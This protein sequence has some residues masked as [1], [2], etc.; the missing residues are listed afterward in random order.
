MTNLS[1]AHSSCALSIIILAKANTSYTFRQMLDSLR[2]Q[3]IGA[4]EILVIDCNSAGDPYSLSL[5]EDISRLDDVRLL[6]PQG[7]RTIGE[8]CNTALEQCCGDYVCFINSSDEWYASKAERQI[9]LLEQAPDSPACCC[10]GYLHASTS[11][12]LD[13]LLIFDQEDV[14]ITRW[15]TTDQF[16][17]SS[18][19]LYRRSALRDAGGFDG[20]LNVCLHQ[21]ALIRLSEHAPVIFCRE[22]LF[23]CSGASALSSP[24]QEYAAAKHLFYKHYDM[25][26]KNRREYQRCS[27]HLGKLAGNC[28]LWLQMALHYIVGVLKAPLVSIRSMFSWI[29]KAAVRK[30]RNLV[31]RLRLAR[32]TR[33]VQREVHSL[34]KHP[35]LPFD[36]LPLQD[37][38]ISDAEPFTLDAKAHSNRLQF[39]NSG[40]LRSVIVPEHMTVIH[41][42][43]FAN[44]RNLER[45]VLPSTVS[46]IEAHAFQGCTQLRYVEFPTGSHLEYVGAY[47]FAGCRMLNDLILA[48]SVSHIGEYAFAGCLSLSRLNFSYSNSDEQSIKPIFPTVLSQLT[49]AVFAGTPI[50]AIEFPEGAMLNAIEDEAFLGCAKLERTHFNGTI[51]HIGRYAFAHCTRLETFIMPKIDAVRVIGPSAF[52]NCCSMTY[53]RLPF[54]QTSITAHCFDGCT[55]LKYIKVPK[56]V[57]YI[58]AHAFRDCR[59][60]ESV[61]ITSPNT[62][63]AHNAFDADIRIDAVKE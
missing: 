4:P 49:R 26:L 38:S 29:G 60:L 14:Q 34:R 35:D 31:N 2:H 15:L 27:F 24:Q 20:A 45:I 40:K 61:I 5:Q 32:Q 19:I 17:V 36:V 23:E 56:K 10:N 62:K 58:E 3:S 22:P 48:G 55:A 16:A 30:T 28:T 6:P 12:G 18:Q 63:Y 59:T 43:M 8:A 39:A 44:C 51:D 54:E 53:F 33:A 47:A 9:S 21:D 11:S 37:M 7:H 57:V 52:R 42:G 1:P 50:S 46:R 13:S 41:Y 25:L